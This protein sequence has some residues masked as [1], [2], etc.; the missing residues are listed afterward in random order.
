MVFLKLIVVVVVKVG[1]VVRVRVMRFSLWVR[2][3]DFFCE[4]GW[5]DE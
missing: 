1:V 2:D 4:N 3:M 5:I